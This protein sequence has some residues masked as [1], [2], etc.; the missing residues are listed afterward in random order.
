MRR[1]EVANSDLGVFLA[2]GIK[3]GGGSA[4]L[5]IPGQVLSG[6]FL[7]SGH[8]AVRLWN[9]ASC[10]CDLLVSVHVACTLLYDPVGYY[11]V[12]STYFQHIVLRRRP[13]LRK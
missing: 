13:V 8:R 4:W 9:G 1:T 2:G 3:P 6:G 5:R 7:L 11:I 10:L 12:A